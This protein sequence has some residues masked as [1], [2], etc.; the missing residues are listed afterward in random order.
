MSEESLKVTNLNRERWVYG[1]HGLIG[2]LLALPALGLIGDWLLSA[3]EAFLVMVVVI[4]VGFALSLPLPF[5]AVGWVVLVGYWLWTGDARRRRFLAAW[6]ASAALSLLALF[7][8][9][10]SVNVFSV[11]LSLLGILLTTLVLPLGYWR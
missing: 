2:L 9:L 7:W 10:A 11:A 1:L 8:L 6:Y 4:M 5:L 3:L